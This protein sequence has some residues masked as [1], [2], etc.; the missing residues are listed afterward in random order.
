MRDLEKEK[1]LLI[2]R[3][4]SN[5][6][7]NGNADIEEG[8]P[9]SALENL[10]IITRDILYLNTAKEL[11]YN[12]ENYAGSFNYETLYFVNHPSSGCFVYAY[13]PKTDKM[14]FIDHLTVSAFTYESFCKWLVETMEKCRE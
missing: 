10:E 11:F 3:I 8:D 12:L 4:Q 14:L 13:S 7:L 1:A 5:E 2:K 6:W 9:F